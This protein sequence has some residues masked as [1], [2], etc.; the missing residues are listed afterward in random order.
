VMKSR[1]RIACPAAFNSGH[2]SRKS[3]PAKWSVAQFCG[4]KIR[5]DD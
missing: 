2:Q 3:R 4:A 1:R 5:F